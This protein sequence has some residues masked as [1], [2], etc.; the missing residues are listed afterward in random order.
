MLSLDFNLVASSACFVAFV[1]AYLVKYR[2]RGLSSLPLPPGPPGKPIVGNLFDDLPTKFEWHTYHEWA[3][4][5]NSD[6]ISMNL[7]GTTFVILDSAEAA[8]DLLECR[9]TIYSDR[10]RFPMV[11]ELMGWDFDFAFMRYGDDWR[12]RR[13]IMH[14]SFHPTAVS[15][16]RPQTQKATHELLRRLLDDPENFFTHV[17]HMGGEIIMS[18][19][20][21]IDVQPKDDPY[22][23]YSDRALRHL[24]TAAIPG[25]FLVDTLPFLKYVPEWM[26]GAG[27]KRKAKEWRKAARLMV[28][29]P[30]DHVKRGI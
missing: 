8:Y 25:A 16:F 30:F 10:M 20:Y 28:E 1:Y 23:D 5:Y 14:Q 2:R 29:V 11:N 24:V 21:G 22:L 18:V 6:I 9:S 15:R 17:R 3:K 27:F 26:P 4:K 13:R 12:Q 19:T 7:A